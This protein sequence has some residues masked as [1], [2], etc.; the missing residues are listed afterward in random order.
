M[1]I[2]LIEFKKLLKNAYKGGGLIVGRLEEDMIL[3]NG[4]GTWGVQV[5]AECVPNKLKGALVELIGDLPEYGEVCRYSPEGIQT[6]LNLGRF[7]FKGL[8]KAAKDYAVQAPFFLQ[9]KWDEYALLQLHSTMEM[10][11]VPR[12][13]IDLISGKDLDHEIE[14]MPGRPSV[15]DDFVIWKNGIMAFWTKFERPREETEKIILPRLSF[16][17]CFGEEPKLLQ[18]DVPDKEEG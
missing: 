14:E 1:F 15:R 3:T 7:D 18:E 10:R 17:D 6:E 12:E 2:N 4:S 5:E 8:W 13:F 9:E 16:L 11:M